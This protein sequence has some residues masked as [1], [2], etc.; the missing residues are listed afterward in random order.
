MLG[1]EY[2]TEILVTSTALGVERSAAVLV[3]HCAGCRVEWSCLIELQ[4]TEDPDTSETQY[5]FRSLK[6]VVVCACFLVY[7]RR[8]FD[9]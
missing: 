8:L 6:G 4:D 5:I 7:S 9:L 3:T 1:P 2:S